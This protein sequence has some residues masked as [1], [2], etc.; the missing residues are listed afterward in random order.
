MSRKKKLIIGISV[1]AAAILVIAFVIIYSSLK[2]AQADSAVQTTTLS[3]AT[4]TERIDV[5]G[6]VYSSTEVKVYSQ[7]P[8]YTVQKINVKVGGKVFKGDILCH[9]NADILQKQ[10][11]QSKQAID[12]AKSNSNQVIK[13]NRNKYESDLANLRNGRNTAVNTAKASMDAAKHS[14]DQSMI[15]YNSAKDA[16]A[17][18]KTALDTAVA[19]GD[20]ATISAAQSAYDAAVQ[21][22]ASADSVASAASSAYE[23]AKTQYQ[24][25]LNAA[26]QQITADRLAIT[27]SQAAAN[28]DAQQTALDS[29]ELQLG[30][31]I[32]Q[33]PIAGTV[34][35]V[36][37]SEGAPSAGVLF[38]VADTDHLQIE[39]KIDEKYINKVSLGDPVKITADAAGTDVYDGKLLSIEP[40]SLDTV[41]SLSGKTQANAD[42]HVKYKAIVDVQANVTRLKM[43]MSVHVIFSVT[44]KD[45][46]FAVGYDALATNAAGETV[47]F[48]L[49][50][51]SQGK[52]SFEAIPV[53]TGVETET[54]VEVSGD[55]LQEGMQIVNSPASVGS[56]KKLLK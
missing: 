44:Q 45:K 43:G 29:L 9:L 4:L 11:Q 12:A 6:T 31:A 55:G 24:S 39:A 17:A 35:A 18:A 15:K 36:N 26:N 25:V 23:N 40:A 20:A 5:K 33:S 34:I 50:K 53:T 22:K 16:L 28:T 56:L 7:L 19:G 46:T 1:A 32:I 38:V 51:D 21:A 47:V 54:L 10:I 13:A 14:H 37:T 27:A 3:L 41:A 8:A 49:T 48:A 30:Q 42:S 2:S 52:V